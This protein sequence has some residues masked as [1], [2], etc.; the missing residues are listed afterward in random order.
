M[1][2]VIV[3]MFALAV[4]ALLTPANA[5]GWYCDNKVCLCQFKCLRNGMW[6]LP[7]GPYPYDAAAA[8]CV[9]RCGRM[10][11]VEHLSPERLKHLYPD[12]PN[13]RPGPS[14]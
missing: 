12:R 10:E 13:V 9:A 6:L 7:S 4:S 8:S 5:R 11:G 2:L 3:G 1:R 14:P